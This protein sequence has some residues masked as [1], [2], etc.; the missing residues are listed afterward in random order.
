MFIQKYQNGDS[1]NLRDH[2][3]ERQSK[4]AAFILLGPTNVAHYFI[5]RFWKWDSSQ[6]FWVSK[7]MGFTRMVL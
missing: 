5:I 2:E 7:M 6:L 3:T 1:A 4:I